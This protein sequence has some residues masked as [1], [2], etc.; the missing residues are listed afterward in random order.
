MAGGF[1]AEEEDGFEAAGTDV[2]SEDEEEEAG[3]GGGGGGA[4]VD[5]DLRGIEGE[6]DLL[7]DATVV[8][9]DC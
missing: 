8:G 1:V 2:A 6:A 7:P 3:G 5:F 9:A 4:A